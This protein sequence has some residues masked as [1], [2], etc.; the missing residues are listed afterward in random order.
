MSG[1]RRRHRLATFLDFGEHRM[2][3]NLDIGTMAELLGSKGPKRRS[4]ER[5]EAGLPIRVYSAYRVGHLL[6]K[7][8]ARAG[9]ERIELRDVIVVQDELA[10]AAQ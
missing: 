2:R 3:A 9:Q 8:L 1:Q 10:I 7:F 6:N 4:L 5:L